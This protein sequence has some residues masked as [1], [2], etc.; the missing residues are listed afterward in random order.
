MS[1]LNFTRPTTPRRSR[2]LSAAIVLTLATGTAALLTSIV[3][4]PPSA[5]AQPAAAEPVAQTQP[6]AEGERRVTPSGLTIIERGRRDEPA[7]AGDR[8]SVLYTGK[9]DNGTVFDSTANRGNQPFSFT[10]GAKQVIAGWD[11]GVAGMRT[12]QK[13]TLIIPANLGYG[14][15]SMGSIPPNS[16]LTFEVEVTGIEPG[17]AR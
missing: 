13:R 3:V 7:K 1:S 10:L 6:T 17:V 12:G 15:R 11:E 5:S 2:R 14:G 16:Q 4:V 8:V 9:L